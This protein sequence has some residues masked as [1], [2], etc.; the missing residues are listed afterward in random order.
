MNFE[1]VDQVDSEN[2]NLGDLRLDAGQLSLTDPG[3]AIAV[4]QHLQNRLRFFLGEWFLDARQ[5]LPYFRDVFVKNPNSQTIRSVFR[6][7][8]LETP[9]ISAVENLELTIASDRTASISFD[10]RLDQGGDPLVFS[11][12]ILGEF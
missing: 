7:T 4:R 12:F 6:R 11:D 10:A 9:G 1:L 3:S 8:I 2:P 5:G